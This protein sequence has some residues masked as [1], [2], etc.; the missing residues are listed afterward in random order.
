MER[1]E[2]ELDWWEEEN[3][4]KEEAERNPWS[5]K[6]AVSTLNKQ[7]TIV[8]CLKLS[9][10]NFHH[11]WTWCAFSIINPFNWLPQDSV[12]FASSPFV[13][14]SLLLTT[15]QQKECARTLEVLENC[16]RTLLKINTPFGLCFR[17][18]FP[19]KIYTTCTFKDAICI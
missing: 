12:S 13:S 5:K 3:L 8:A 1:E 17:E 10:L 11:C 7:T 15:W 19:K 18:I 6:R 4:P 14:V 2:P 16:I 9:H